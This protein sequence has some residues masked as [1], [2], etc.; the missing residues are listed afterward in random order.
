[1][2]AVECHW[3]QATVKL[4]FRAGV[5][6]VRLFHLHY[7]GIVSAGEM[8]AGLMP[9]PPGGQQSNSTI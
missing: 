3:H 4:I 1:M 2:K 7:L 5:E 8:G 9:C 6:Y